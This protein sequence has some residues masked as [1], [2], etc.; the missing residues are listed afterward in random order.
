V[1]HDALKRN[2][3]LIVHP[4]E[5]RALLVGEG[6]QWTLPPIAGEDAPAII[7]ELRA[8]PGLETTV[9]G[10][11]YQG[12]VADHRQGHAS[13]EA[14]ATPSRVYALEPRS[15]VVAES[16]TKTLWVTRDELDGLPLAV[17]THRAVIAAWLRDVE[18]GASPVG[19]VPWARPGW[20]DVALAWMGAEATRDNY[21]LIGPPQQL[22]VS[23]WSTVYR[24]PATPVGLYFKAT[25]P[26]F[27]YEPAVS[28]LLGERLGQW[29]PR[30]VATDATHGWLLS[31]D[32]GTMLRERIETP[33]GQQRFEE[34]LRALAAMQQASA[35]AV[36]E[37]L[38]A[39]CPDY[40]LSALP[41]RFASLAADREALQVGRVGGVPEEE[42]AA[43]LALAPE[44]THICAQ[45]AA[46]GIPMTLHHD[47]LGPGNVLESRRGEL[48]L[49]DWGE[50]GVAHPFCSLM[51]PL[52]WAKLVLAYDE[53]GLERLQE[54]YVSAWRVSGTPTQLREALGL[55]HRLGYLCRA[56]TYA[57]LRPHLEPQL[58]GEYADVVPYWLRL[59][60]RN[61]P[62][63][64]DVPDAA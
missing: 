57:T 8:E 16:P 64:G 13:A 22:K 31:E 54:A 15:S 1:E 37:L 44:V 9:L 50:C 17:E 62:P 61:A 20:R 47:D 49:F 30:V 18:A 3:A 2:Y 53:A 38:A 14:E 46:S 59:F 4:A 27:A 63:G 19:R 34:A 48:L 45:L 21:Q 36:A 10:L 55:A 52:R 25:A 51:I 56:L 29:V 28:R 43:L 11:V 12:T 23:L 60:L 5:P 39:G 35:P 26:M 42:Y 7:A 58:W 24:A 41:E 6:K 33:E 40:R 32:G